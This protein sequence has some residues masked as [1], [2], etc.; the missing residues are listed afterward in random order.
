MFLQ[1]VPARGLGICASTTNSPRSSTTF[2]VPN[3]SKC[4]YNDPNIYTYIFSIDILHTLQMILSYFQISD[5]LDK[6]Y[7]DN[8]EWEEFLKTFHSLED[9]N[10]YIKE[11]KVKLDPSIQARRLFLSMVSI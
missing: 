3:Q 2:E 5:P 10:S 1:Q 4:K 11:N 8:T 9:L 6:W 7:I